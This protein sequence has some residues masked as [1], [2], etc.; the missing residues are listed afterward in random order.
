MKNILY[1]VV[2]ELI[3][4]IVVIKMIVIYGVKSRIMLIL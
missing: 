3:A 2:F 1:M 4:K